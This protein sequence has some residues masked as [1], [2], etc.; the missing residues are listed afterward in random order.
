MKLEA[1]KDKSRATAS[2]NW[3]TRQLKEL[4]SESVAVRA[5]W[6]G[7]IMMTSATL[8]EAL[9][10]PNSLLPPGDRVLPS[11]LEVAR[12]IDLAARF[13]GA[14]TFVEE[15][16][17]G[18]ESFYRDVGQHLS[19]WVP[20]APKIKA[21]ESKPENIELSSS[22]SIDGNSVITHNGPGDIRK[23]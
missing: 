1:P 10:D 5:H 4:D 19:K 22:D 15:S 12:V 21:P 11:Y 13:K 23:Q 18:L 2:I 17:S 9:E 3:L 20:K 7:R 6:P 8:Q 14:K 16:W